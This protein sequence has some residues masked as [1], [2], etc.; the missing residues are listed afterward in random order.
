[1][2]LLSH[3]MANRRGKVEEVIDFTFLGSK[4]RIW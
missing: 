4:I 2:A 1:M 3:F